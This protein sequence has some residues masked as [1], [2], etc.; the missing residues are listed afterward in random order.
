MIETLYFINAI[1]LS[2]YTKQHL[3]DK[4]ESEMFSASNIYTDYIDALIYANLKLLGIKNVQKATN[5]Y[6]Q[7]INRYISDEI[8]DPND[9]INIL[10]DDKIKYFPRYCNGNC[11]K[12]CDNCLFKKNN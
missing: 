2:M 8:R 11:N 5:E 3:F 7:L 4:L 9:I 12:D 10:V 1:I 6:K